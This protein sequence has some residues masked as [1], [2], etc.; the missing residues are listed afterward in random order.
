M[1]NSNAF[2]FTDLTLNVNHSNPAVQSKAEETLKGLLNTSY[3]GE[4]PKEFFEEVVII[5]DWCKRRKLKL[6]ELENVVGRQGMIDFC[7]FTQ[8]SI[9]IHLRVYTDE[10][11]QFIEKDIQSGHIGRQL[12]AVLLSE[13]TRAKF[14]DWDAFTVTIET[15]AQTLGQEISVEPSG[16][17]TLWCIHWHIAQ[18][19]SLA[20]NTI[21]QLD[22]RVGLIFTS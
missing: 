12:A 13:E 20:C 17:I 19:V 3:Q 7:G 14:K 5:R 2:L 6:K 4:G 15:G 21:I 9:H 11:L 22:W 1:K 16:V 18:F 8:D 10:G